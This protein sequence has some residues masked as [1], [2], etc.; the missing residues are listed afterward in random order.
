MFVY[1]L[2][3]TA[4]QV[5]IDV[6]PEIRERLL[7]ILEQYGRDGVSQGELVE[8]SGYSK[9]WVS[10]V[11]GEL[12]ERGL[13]ARVPGP[14]KTKRVVLSKFLDPSIGRTVRV[15]LVRASE[16]VYLPNL[17]SHLRSHGYE[18]ELVL[19]G[20]VSEATAALARG[21]V[22]LSITPIYTQAAYRALGAPIKAF[23][24]G[25]LGGASLVY[26][27][28]GERVLSSRASTMEIAAIAIHR[29]S[30]YGVPELR[31]YGK[32]EEGV[33]AFVRGE[34]EAIAIW[35]PYA[36]EL[37]KRGYSRIRLAE[38]IGNYYCCTLAKHE[39]LSHEVNRYIE[40]SWEEA[41]AEI[42]RGKTYTDSLRV[43]DIDEAA[44]KR[45]LKEYE[46]TEELEWDYIK[47]I[48]SHTA[49]FLVNRTTIGELLQD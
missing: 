28:L 3:F 34:A 35:E 7:K 30:G 2:S 22:H 21:E 13:V 48:L 11:L 8:E 31:Y 44:V 9:S 40:K 43:L 10:E 26:R 23:R 6:K 47:K 39:N 36:S 38:H 24:G 16:Y 18:V 5:W 27:R 14:G 20:N 12:E 33:R 45:A 19:Y 1:Y 46:F 37:E 42:R 32:P 29:A 15:G 17:I 49:G 25:A 41:L 4:M